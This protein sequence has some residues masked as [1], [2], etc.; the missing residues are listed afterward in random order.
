MMSGSVA[1]A[2]V[3]DIVEIDD[4][5][6]EEREFEVGV[7]VFRGLGAAWFVGL[8]GSSGEVEVGCAEG[9]ECY[10][11]DG[12]SDGLFDIVWEVD[13]LVEFDRETL[14][15]LEGL[16]EV[17]GVFAERD[18]DYL[19]GAAIES[20]GV[21]DGMEVGDGGLEFLDYFFGGFDEPVFLTLFLVISAEANHGVV[22]FALEVAVAVDVAVGFCAV[23]DAV[24]AAE[25]L[26]ETV[27]TEVFVDVEGVEEFG[28]ETSE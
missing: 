26:D 24:G 16:D 15:L 28:V 23:E 17:V 21:H 22:E 20:H 18:V 6:A 9:L 11:W 5:G 27:P 3:H 8:A 25:G 4:S 13:V 2:E 7:V 1:S 14:D 12:L 19:V 10:F